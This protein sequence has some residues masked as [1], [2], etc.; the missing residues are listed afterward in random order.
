MTDFRSLYDEK[1][2]YVQRRRGDSPAAR[3]VA[4]EVQHYKLP[5]LT[6]VLPA[7]LSLESIAEIGCGTGEIIAGFQ[8]HRQMRRV[9]FDIS[10][11]NVAAAQERFP[12]VQFTDQDFLKCG[13]TFDVVILSDVIEHVPNDAE[14]LAAAADL[15]PITLVNLPLEKC[16]LYRSRPYGPDDPSGHLRSYSFDDGLRLFERAGLKLL[17]W[18]QSWPI[19][20]PQEMMRQQLNREV[21]GHRFSG[22]L[23]SRLAKQGVYVLSTRIKPIGR[24]LFPSNLFAS[25]GKL[26]SSSD[27][28]QATESGAVN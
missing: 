13:E 2:E 18:V 14:F 24:R 9:G 15:A 19:E 8:S 5:N 10:P 16:W 27:A 12:H 26:R 1:A 6:R 3:R 4:L 21:T 11:R 17:Q 22:S 25:L 20:E 23:V 7:E 28:P